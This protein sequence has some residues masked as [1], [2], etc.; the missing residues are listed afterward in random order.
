MSLYNNPWK[1]SYKDWIATAFL[2]FFFL[3]GKKA[4]GVGE[5]GTQAL[6]VLTTIVPLVGTILV[7]Y[8][9]QELYGQYSSYKTKANNANPNNNGSN[10]LQG[11]L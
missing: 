5:S 9:G 11:P 7:G 2:G 3:V 10:N 8:F 4:V 6:S 1:F